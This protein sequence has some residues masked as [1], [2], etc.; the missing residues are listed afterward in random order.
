MFF[1]SKTCSLY[2]ANQKM[3]I[4]TIIY[5]NECVCKQTK[6]DKFRSRRYT[7]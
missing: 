6:V 4:T 5:Q 7:I 3:E 2:A 1:L